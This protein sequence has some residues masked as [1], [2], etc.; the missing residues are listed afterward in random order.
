MTRLDPS[1]KLQKLLDEFASGRG[2]RLDLGPHSYE[3]EAPLRVSGKS[4]TVDGGAH[5]FSDSPNAEHESQSGSVLHCAEDGFHI[6]NHDPALVPD[7]HK[8]GG[9][10]LRNL[11]LW[12]S[13]SQ[14][15]SRAIVIDH[16]IDQS[17]FENVHIGNFGSG[18]VSKSV[19]DA[20]TIRGLDIIH[21][22]FGMSVEALS[23]YVRLTDSVICD[24]DESGLVVD[25]VSGS[26]G[27]IVAN[28]IV[29]R[30]GRAPTRTKL[31]CNISWGG[32]G[33]TLVNNVIQDAGHHFYNEA[34]H[35]DPEA[36]APASGLI[37]EGNENIVAMNQ[38]QDHR[39]GPAIIVRGRGNRLVANGF[40]ANSMDIVIEPSAHDSVIEQRG[41]V[42]VS[43]QGIRTVI[44]NLAYN[45]GDPDRSGEWGD[46]AKW[47][48]LT[49]HD[50]DAGITW[51]YGTRF[52]CGRIAVSKE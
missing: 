32:N 44:N 46:A 12:G 40:R 31:P 4:T 36:Y 13:G 43:D 1:S 51:I 8:L 42:Q 48:G 2:G 21:C 26:F 19:M 35:G 24:N 11:Y 17:R 16:D 30:N 41:D 15:E 49:V 22:G 23:V 14:G 3:V 5:G 39:T 38:F 50:L 37:I 28:C 34:V 25:A 6:G 45:H 29:V 9:I 52:N 27:W 18:L 33:S 7:R 47:D 20:P 10:N